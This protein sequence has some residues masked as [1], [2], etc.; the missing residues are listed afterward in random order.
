MG[1][2]PREE[3]SQTGMSF[4]CS[5]TDGGRQYGLFPVRRVQPEGRLSMGTGGACNQC[6]RSAEF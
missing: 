3:Y 4:N 1:R 2:A 5:Q 6:E